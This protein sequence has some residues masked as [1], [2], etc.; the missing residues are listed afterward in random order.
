MTK[1]LLSR[2]APLLAALALAPLPALAQDGGAKSR[3]PPPPGQQLDVEELNDNIR[4]HT[5]KKVTVVGEIEEFLDSRSFI[6]ESGGLFNDE[7]TVVFP[8]DVKGLPVLYLR[9]DTDVVVTG[10][11][12]ALR[13][14]DV[15][16]ELSW[17]LDPEI[18]IELE[19]VTHFLVAD[20][21]TRQRR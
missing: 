13:V 15:K 21:V 12:R 5:G 3:P 14:L 7:I 1:A 9:E 2:V 18:E 20:K 4:A 10:T 8:R 6:L 17:D 16:R 11:V 19:R